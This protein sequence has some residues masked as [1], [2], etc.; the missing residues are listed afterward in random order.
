MQFNIK[1]IYDHDTV[2]IAYARPY[3][4]TEI[5]THML[6][7]EYNLCTVEENNKAT[8]YLNKPFTMTVQN[9]FVYKRRNMCYTLSGLPVPYV[10][11]T[12]APQLGKRPKMRE[13]IIISSRVHPG[14]TNSSFVFHG[15][16]ESLVKLNEPDA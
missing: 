10:T 2:Y 11:I 4:Y 15:I 8:L 13:A 1:F 7:L 14:E 5:I 6:M 9:K 3:S 12:A 16:I